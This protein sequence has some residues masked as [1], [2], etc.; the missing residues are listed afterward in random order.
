MSYCLNS[1]RISGKK[2]GSHPAND[3]GLYDMHGNVEEWC[4]DS[5]HPNYIDAPTNSIAW[6]SSN[7]NE[8]VVRGGR[9]VTSPG[10]CRSAARKLLKIDR[11]NF[12]GGWPGFR[13]VCC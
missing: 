3:F 4:A 7:S 11:Y 12:E 2:V 13:V 6:V 10:L 8:R 1:S 9:G 5:W